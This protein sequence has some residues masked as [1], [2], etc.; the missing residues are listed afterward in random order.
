MSVDAGAASSEIERRVAVLNRRGLH[1]RAAAKLV[2]CARKFESA[3]TVTRDGNTVSALSIM[4]LMTL[5]AS[6]GVTLDVRAKGSDA[7]AALDAVAA[8]FAAKFN[9]D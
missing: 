1:A 5:G 3:I 2:E 4:G 9:E 8:L 6:P 7:S